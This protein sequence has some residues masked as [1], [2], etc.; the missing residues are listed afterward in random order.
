ML[1]RI[2]QFLSRHPVLWSSFGLFALNAAVIHRLFFVEYTSHMDSIEGAYIG[3]SRYLLEHPF[4]FGWFGDWYTGIPYQNTY[5]PF[6]HMLVAAVA[7]VLHISPALSHHAVSAF[8]YSLGPVAV[9]WLMRRISGDQASSLVAA[10][11]YSLVSPS[12]LASFLVHRWTGPVGHAER[13]NSLVA[14]GDGPHVG[15]LTLLPLAMLALHCSLEKRGIVRLYGAA[16]AL[17]VVVLTNWLGAFALALAVV[18]Y[19]LARP[20]KLDAGLKMAGIG[21]AAYALALPWIPPS[22]IVAIQYNAQFTIGNYP[23]TKNHIYYGAGI[24]VAAALLRWILVRCRAG[25]AL[26]FMAFFLLFTGVIVEAD[27]R[28]GISLMPQPSRYNLEAELGAACVLAFTLVPLVRRCPR[29]IQVALMVLA[30]VAGAIQFNSFRKQA[31]TIIQTIDV[32]KTVEYEAAHWFRDHIPGQRVFLTG[33]T[34]FWLSAF[35]DVPQV[36]GGFGQGIVNRTIPAIH[37]GIPWLEG[38]GKTL[39]MWMRL[40]GA[41][42]VAVNGPKGRDA[43]SIAWRDPNKF[44]GILPELWRDGDD[45]IY[46]VPQRSRSLAH[47]VRKSSADSHSPENVLDLDAVRGLAA[48]LEDPDLAVANLQW[49]TPDVARITYNNES[50]L[51][52]EQMLFVQISYHPGWRA[53]SAGRDVPIKSN[54]LGF[55]ELDPHC[56]GPCEVTLTFDGGREMAV[57]HAACGGAFVLGLALWLRERRRA[58]KQSA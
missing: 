37:F 33:A 2:L 25:L 46:D 12:I 15:S 5:P 47:V 44:V 40:Y 38:E 53:Q 35:A 51:A 4:Q 43:Y 16:V 39:A 8:L 55:M 27:A 30:C 11:I 23:I 18:S 3:L 10:L 6:L 22:T 9:Y 28:F 13:L 19:L 32:S 20:W 56:S 49:T 41:N 42:A 58:T 34:Q 31:G 24:I 54:G 45:V 52:S 7:G 14:F 48:D 1:K 36:G 50:N 57:A 26:S 29:F 21:A 17:M